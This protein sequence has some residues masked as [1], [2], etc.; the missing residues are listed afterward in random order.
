MNII[1]GLIVG[2]VFFAC[3]LK[4]YCIGL[5]HSKQLSNGIIP[6]IELNPLKE[7]IEHFETKQEAKEVKSAID[8]YWR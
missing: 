5:Q 2:L 6:T 1:I 8:E 7:V 3:T 4:A